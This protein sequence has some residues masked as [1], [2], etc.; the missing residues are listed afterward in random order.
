MKDGL[1]VAHPG[2]HYSFAHPH[3]ASYLASEAIAEA[4][5]E[6]AADLSL[7]P[8]WQDALSF[9]SA[10]IDMYPAIQ[11][12]LRRAPD[13]LF[14]ALFDIVRWLPDAPSDA[15]WR[16]D[17]FKRLAA[18]LMAPE[19]FP[20]VRE[21]SMAALIAA[22]DKNVLFILRQALRAADSTIRRLG[23]VGLGALGNAEAVKDLAPMLVDHERDV[24]LAAGLALGAIG[25]ERALEIMVHGLLDGS[26][27]LR[28]AVAEALA[29][30]P[31]EGH[32]ILRDG[33]ESEDIMIRRACVYGLSRVKAP[34]AL[35]TL[36][37]TM[38]EDEQWYVRT[39][40]EEAFMAAQSPERPG[41][42]THP[43]ADALLWLI[44]WAAE[45]GEGV[46]AGPNARQVLVRALQE[47][48]PNRQTLAA[49]TLARLGHIPATTTLY[50][51][52]R[53][54]TP[55]VRSAA[56]DALASLQMQLGEP[57]PGLV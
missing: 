54:R 42:R 35:I 38:M 48:D 40:A 41:P 5:P 57:L 32:A 20:T 2:G 11:R 26:E 14:S 29:A 52:L 7:E 23:C 18:A 56:Y 34:W 55:E 24:Q 13:L 3:L 4:G 30:I 43:E 1:L 39:A 45:R 8:L 22:R 16:G 47:G 31:G 37:R 51:A 44:E 46:P 15:H 19:Q 9:A 25:T 28:Q 50:A 36:Y 33:V 27:E 53:E 49:T 6:Q 17:L 12:K 10:R 21:R